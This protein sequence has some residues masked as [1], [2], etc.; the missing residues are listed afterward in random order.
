MG[1]LME[2]FKKYKVVPVALFILLWMVYF[3]ISWPD[4]SSFRY[5]A[6]YPASKP[7]STSV[8]FAPL[9]YSL[10]PELTNLTHL[11]YWPPTPGDQVDFLASTSPLT[12]TYHLRGPAQ[13]SYTLGKSLEAI[14]VARDHKGRPKI[15]G[16][17]L[18]RAQLLGP[19][20]KAGVAGDIQDL[21]NG[22]YLLSFPLLW[23]GKAQVQVRLI[24]SSEAVAVLRRIW[25]EKKAT[26]DFKGYFRGPTGAEETVI[27]NV[28]PQSTEAKGR[29][30][31][32]R[33][34]DSGELWFCA[35]PPTL[36][37]ESLVGHS[38]GRYLKVTTQHDDALLAWNV[39][40]KVLPQGISPIQIRIAATRNNSLALSPPHP[41]CPGLPDPKP[42]GF[43]H[44]D[45]W[46][47]LTCSSRSFSTSDSILGCLA[48]RVVHM[49]GDS[50]LR[51]WWEYLHDT[52]PSLKP[53]D[54]HVTYQTGPLMAVEPTRNIVL[55]WR[56]HGWPLR[57]LRTPV[58]SLHSV[59]R[60]L[61]GLAGGPHTV[62]VL[63]LGAHFT[64]FPPTIF[65][66]RLAGIRAAVAA[67]LAREPLTLVVIK[68][69]NTGYKSVYGSDWFTLQ[70]NRLLRAA[71]ADLRV[72]FVDAWE[73]TS[74]LAL[75][76]DIHPGRLIVSNEV[77]F[78]LSFLCPAERPCGS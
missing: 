8:E 42:S 3:I 16:G 35:Q 27:C 17:D 40:D 6:P 61:G 66:R 21:E 57:S 59:V 78:L 7:P 48:G 30:C 39:T 26:V 56:A 32:Y 5:P 41:C 22:T 14:L 31:Q 65:A 36:P 33:D 29:T 9:L 67:L 19:D 37:C 38:S 70:L 47:S 12:S 74:S 25:R 51:Q 52:V 55:H 28:D 10:P 18:F 77:N 75:P 45:V 43:Y 1:S 54:L 60:E 76:D 72:A 58:A 15:H 24:H 13:A 2:Q 11:L 64:T 69:A 4:S 46:H 53:V 63:G 50:T 73:M 20:L 23:A 44:Q 68:L 49:M 71:F 62:V 34:A